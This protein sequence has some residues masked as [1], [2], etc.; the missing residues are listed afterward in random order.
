MLFKKLLHQKKKEASQQFKELSMDARSSV[1]IIP[2][3]VF[4]NET[5]DAETLSKLKQ[6]LVAKSDAFTLLVNH[7]PVVSLKKYR[8]L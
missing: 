3:Q 6:S 4:T 7:K 2:E 8:G 1:K 5:K